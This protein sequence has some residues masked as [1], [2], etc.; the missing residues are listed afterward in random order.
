MNL[1]KQ[2]GNVGKRNLQCVQTLRGPQTGTQFGKGAQGIQGRQGV[3][4][5][6]V[7]IQN[8]KIQ[9]NRTIQSKKTI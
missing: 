6:N 9:T 1:Q 7:T 2:F 5:G 3:K 8:K 4:T